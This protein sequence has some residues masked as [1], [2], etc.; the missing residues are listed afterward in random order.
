MRPNI[1]IVISD[2]QGYG[3]LS[4]HGNPVLKTPQLDRLSDESVRL[5]DYHVAPTC[6]PTRAALLTGHWQNRTGVWHTIAGRSLLRESETT[7]ATRLKSAGYATAMFG[8]WHLG[9]NYPNRPQDRGFDEVFIHG[10][11]GVGQTP[12]FWD[13]AYFDGSYFRA[14][15][16][17][18]FT[19]EV[20]T[21]HC[22]DVWFDA[23]EAYIREQ[24]TAD[25][26]FFA[27]VSTNAPHGPY[28]ARPDYAAHYADQP[29]KVQHFFG[30]IEH[31]DARVGT[32]RQTLADAGVADNTLLLFTTDN[33]TAAGRDVWNAG[34][35]G[36]KGSAYDGGHRVPAFWSWPAA[37]IGGG[38]D[39]DTL[40]AHV[41][42][43]PT[44]L[45][46]IGQPLPDDGDGV[47][48]A[49]LIRGESKSLPD[50]VVITDSQRVQT[51]VRHRQTA[52]MTERWRLVNNTELF[53]NDADPE[54]RSNV[55]ADHPD[56]VA[57]LRAAYDDWWADLQPAMAEVVS[58]PL[59]DPAA[60]ITHLTAHDWFVDGITPWNQKMI[61]AGEGLAFDREADD[62]PFWNVQF[63]RPGQYRIELRR[64]PAEAAVGYGAG[65]PA[66]EPVPGTPAFRTAPG[67]PLA[68][69]SGT[70]MVSV[71]HLVGD[72]KVG[73]QVSPERFVG[74]G[75]SVAVELSI[76]SRAMQTERAQLSAFFRTTEGD[77]A[78]P[79][80]TVTYLAEETKAK[81][82]KR[83]NRVVINLGG[84]PRPR[85][86]REDGLTSRLPKY[87]GPSPK[88]N[89]E[90]KDRIGPAMQYVR[91][92]KPDGVRV[93]EAIPFVSRESGDQLLDVYLPAGDGPFPVV[94]L[95]HGG[96]WRKG[97]R[98]AEASRAY[99]LAQRGI[100]S[101]APDYRLGDAHPYPALMHDLQQA[102]AWLKSDRHDF[103]LDRDRVVLF[104]GSA[105]AHMV[106]LAAATADNPELH[107]PVLPPGSDLSVDGVA[108][109]AGPTD[110]E[111]EDAAR[112]SRRE[113]SNYDVL[114]GGSI[115]EVPERY[116]EFNPTTWVTQSMPPVLLINENSRE[117]S[118]RFR[119]QLDAAHVPHTSFVF[120]RVR[121]PSWHWSPWFAF[122]MDRTLELC[123]EV[124]QDE[125][126]E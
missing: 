18:D 105:G 31:I 97:S 126:S 13:N 15:T 117:K 23:A 32:L 17:S 25:R 61:R 9:D 53:D 89:Q 40:T 16:G 10:G 43:M 57:R 46:L 103:P 67:Q 5:T 101:V 125:G 19:A 104:G 123:R 44:L 85:Y 60:P 100:A 14:T 107:D 26:P 59:G 21:G 33:G 108:I 91:L 8:K 112:E 98:T 114:L 39:V 102:I 119:E 95:V 69:K 34:M 120:E 24:A 56:V 47:S 73:Y 118:K 7:L 50:R 79:Y 63:R 12:D 111:N 3:D 41:D 78:A 64:W 27:Y 86:A 58:I 62:L 115:D 22:T 52:V 96:G 88:T 28:H 92:P 51:P 82:A 94:M 124:W 122:T 55:L 42:I 4:C 110:T 37:G 29:L 93:I 11:G 70:A 49:S 90:W 81:A 75:E 6:S 84:K 116:R 68:I 74:K 113:G 80:V 87:D 106:A 121:H 48:L 71:G 66:G 20:V 36:G 2:D 45:E 72:R 35:R 109:I 38:R 30:M 99:W 83:K 54:Q 76:D 65:L 1:V 77:F